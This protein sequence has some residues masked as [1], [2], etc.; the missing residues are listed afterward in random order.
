MRLIHSPGAKTYSW[1]RRKLR[2]AGTYFRGNPVWCAWQVTYRC[3]FRCAFC[4]YWKE[5][6]GADGELTAAQFAVGGEKLARL[7][8]L[9]ISLAGG[10]PLLRDDL[11]DVIRVLARHH[12]PMMT[13]NGFGLS[14]ARAREL[15]SAGLVGASV[16][17]DYADERKHDRRRGRA[18]VGTRR[19]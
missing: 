15:W 1:R 4:G 11:A 6:A 8:T 13:T 7:G 2:L 17:L 16:S 18:G 14:T 12:L 5:G 9:L 3:N 19:N 10:E